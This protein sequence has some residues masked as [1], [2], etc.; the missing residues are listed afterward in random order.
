MRRDLLHISTLGMSKEDW[1]DFRMRGIG[2]SEI[3]SLMGLSPY[4]S[5]TELF[6]LKAGLIP[7]SGVDNEATFWG[8]ALEE[9]VASNWQYWGGS[10]E[11]M[12]E[13]V[14]QNKVVRRCQRVNAYLNNP[15]YPHLFVSLDRKIVGKDNGREGCLEIKTI[16]GFSSNQWEGGIPI[17]HIVQ[18]QCQLLVTDLHYGELAILKDGRY[19]EVIPF[20]RNEEIVKNIVTLSADFWHN[21]V[22]PARELLA[23]AGAI[24]KDEAMTL[25]QQFEPDPDGSDAYTQ[26]LS[27]RY[28]IG[29]DTETIDGDIQLLEWAEAYTHAHQV[30]KDN[31]EQKQYYGN[32][33]KA[34]MKDAAVIDFGTRGRVTWKNTVKGNRT[35]SVK[36]KDE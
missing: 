22:L 30:A 20:E 23:E 6:Y 33:I 1:L 27:A 2:A 8:K 11:S 3:G 5:S 26:F 9:V 19:M 34:R 14:N 25:V 32:L 12:I 7:N 31:E 36:I 28:C 4:F 17:Y 21:R 13:N 29:K 24:G 18:L 35:F 10:V 16:S 15:A